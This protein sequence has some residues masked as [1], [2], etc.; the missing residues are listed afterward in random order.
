MLEHWLP[1]DEWNNL[2]KIADDY[3]RKQM[4]GAYA[5]DGKRTTKGCGLKSQLTR[6]FVHG[7]MRAKKD[8]HAEVVIQGEL[9]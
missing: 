1:I 7:Y 6:A 2:R 5:E 3:G 4:N 8:S 9:K